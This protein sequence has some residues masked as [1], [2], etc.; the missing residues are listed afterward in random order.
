MSPGVGVGVAAA[1][2]DVF[3]V[4][5]LVSNKVAIMPGSQ[6]T[7]AH[8]VNLIELIWLMTKPPLGYAL[9]PASD[10]KILPN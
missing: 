6:K 1:V 2:V 9:A 3:F 7:R 10:C 5:Q 4:A 8:F